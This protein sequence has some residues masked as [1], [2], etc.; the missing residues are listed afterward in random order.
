MAEFATPSAAAMATMDADADTSTASK[1]N[2]S[3]P[4]RPD[5]EA[6]KKSLAEAEKELAAVQEKQ[7][8]SA[9][10]Y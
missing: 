10:Y 3:K 9:R 7:V 8:G 1:V 6:Y 2:V 5:E 4:E